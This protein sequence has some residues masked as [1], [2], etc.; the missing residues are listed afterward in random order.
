MDKTTVQ[1]QDDLKSIQYL[2]KTKWWKVFCDILKNA[3]KN[4][5]IDILNNKWRDEKVYSQ[6]DLYK[7]AI[8][9]LTYII[10]LPNRLEENLENILKDEVQETE[11]EVGDVDEL[12]TEVA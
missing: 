1:K 3:R 6:A 11:I 8:R 2:M 4:K 5:T 10:E 7:E 12:F 9:Q